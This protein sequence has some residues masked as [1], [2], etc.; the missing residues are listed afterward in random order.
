MRPLRSGWVTFGLDGAARHASREA[1]AAMGGPLDEWKARPWKLI[2]WQHRSVQLRDL[3]LEV[4]RTGR[5]EYAHRGNVHDGYVS[6]VTNLYVRTQAHGR[7]TGGVL[8]LSE[9]LSPAGMPGRC[10]RCGAGWEH[11]VSCACAQRLCWGCARLHE[12]HGL[13]VEPAPRQAHGMRSAL[14]TIAKALIL[15]SETCPEDAGACQQSNP[16]R[17][18]RLLQL[19]RNRKV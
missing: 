7:T 13:L 9:G 18:L 11:T 14:L 16:Q 15:L 3:P 2:D 5:P 19:V 12:C 4:I 1:E 10:E 6:W 17:A 8:L